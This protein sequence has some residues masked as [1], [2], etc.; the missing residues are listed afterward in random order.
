MYIVIDIGGTF[1]K[2]ALMDSSGNIIEKGK[3]PTPNADLSAFTSLIFSIIE[4]QDLSKVK[5]TAISCPGTIDV[6]NGV[7]YHGGLLTFLHEVNL[8]KVIYDRFGIDVSIE[9]DAK[10]AALAELWL[11]S[12]KDAKDAVVLVLGSGVGGGIIVDGKLHRGFNLS[13]GEVSFVM[14]EVNGQTK[15][16]EFVGSQSSAVRMVSRIAELKKL[17]NPTD[18]EAVFD[19]I[20]GHDKEANAIFDEYCI[21][22][23]TL[24][25]NLQY[26]LDPEIFA[27]GGGISSQPV[28]LERIQ[29]AINELKQKY[30]FHTANPK[31]VTCQFRN[32]ANLYGALYHYLLTKEK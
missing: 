11:G 26:I 12:V 30:P 21:H 28:V 25:L 22:L 3:R 20:N 9:N 17:D 27:I 6:K 16:G 13:A 31:V 24:I 14:S 2:F 4:E 18:G 1:V 5:G 32:D 29:W 15:E 10:C 23:G 8:V 19:F 7:I